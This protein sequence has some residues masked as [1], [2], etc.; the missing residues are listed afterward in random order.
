MKKNKPDWETFPCE[1]CN[2]YDVTD[3]CVCH[4][5]D[6][7]SENQH[8]ETEIEKILEGFDENTVS[9]SECID[10]ADECISALAKYS[11]EGSANYKFVKSMEKVI[12]FARPVTSNLTEEEFNDQLWLFADRET[13]QMEKIKIKGIISRTMRL[14][15]SYPELARKV[16]DNMPKATLDETGNT[17]QD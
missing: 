12:S 11:K 15:L 4:K 5:L 17:K 3:D 8:E 10:Y 1:D 9:L 7:W 14:C 2:Y 6:E 13:N 16:N